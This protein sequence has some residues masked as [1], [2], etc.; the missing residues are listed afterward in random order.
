MF[1]NYYNYDP[2]DTE[3]QTFERR[4]EKKLRISA[5]PCEMQI[6]SWSQIPQDISSC[7][8][9]F[10]M[11]NLCLSELHINSNANDSSP[12]CAAL[13]LIWLGGGGGACRCSRLRGEAAPA[14]DGGLA[15]GDTDSESQTSLPTPCPA[16]PGD[17]NSFPASEVQSGQV[18]G[19]Q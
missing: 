13:F 19:P 4:L 7:C 3:S 12:P 8:K 5:L 14:P 17:L 11:R 1:Q 6:M 15:P 9:S 10:L 2:G 18:R 16:C